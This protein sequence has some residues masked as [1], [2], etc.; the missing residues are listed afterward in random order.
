MNNTDKIYKKYDDLEKINRNTRQFNRR[1]ASKRFTLRF[2]TFPVMSMLLI[3][4]ANYPEQIKNILK[5]ERK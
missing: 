4:I 2:K 5:G 3:L 1:M